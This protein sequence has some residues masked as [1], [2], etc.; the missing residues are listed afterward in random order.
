VAENRK[1]VVVIVKQKLKVLE[2]FENGEFLTRLSN[3]IHE[4]MLLG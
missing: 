2:E 4:M 1:K 3:C